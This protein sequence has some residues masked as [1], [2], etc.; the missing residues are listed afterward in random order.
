MLC[1][2]KTPRPDKL[3][4]NRLILLAYALIILT[5]SLVLFLAYPEYRLLLVF[6]FILTTVCCLSL[7]IKTIN[8]AEEAITY[9]GFANEIIKNKYE[10]IRIDNSNGEPVIQNDL[11]QEMFHNDNLLKFLENHL[12]GQSSNSAALYRLKTAY[13]DLVSEKVT[14]SLILQ[15]DDSKIF[16]PEEWYTIS[17]KPIYLKK[18]DIFEGKFSVKAIKKYTYIYWKL[19]NITASKNM[20]QVFQEERKS[21]HD[22]L[23][24]LPVGVYTCNEDYRIEYCNHALA[25]ALGYNRE[26]IIGENLWRFLSPHCELPEKHSLWKG[27][28]YLIGANDETKEYFVAQESFREDKE[29]KFRGVMISDLPNDTELQQ[30]LEHSLDEISWLFNDAPVGIA[31]INTEGQIQ[32][33]NSAVEKFLDREKGLIIGKRIFD[34]MR[35]EECDLLQKEMQSINGTSQ[36]SKAID[37]HITLD[38]SEKIASLYLSP[39]QK[40]HT[41]HPEQIDGLVV[42]VIDATQQKSLEMQFAQAQKMQA[43]GQMAGGVAHDFNNLLTAMIGF[44]DLLLQRHGVGDPS[45]TDLI[46][47][48]QNA[49]RAAGLVRQLLAFSRKQPLKPKLIDVTENF[50]EL[51]QMLKRILGEQIVLHFYH[52]NDLGFI[53]VDPVQFSQVIINLAVNAKDAMNGNGTL[54]ITTRVET[55]TTPYQFGADTIK[56]G[57]FVVIDVTDT[58]C[59]IPPENLNR[60]FEPFFSTKQNV[61]GS[62]TGLGLATVY[63]IVRQTEG[64]IKV[65]S[66]L[67]KGTTFSIHLPRF[68]KN[69]DEEEQNLIETKERIT[70][71]DGT[72]ILTVQEKRTSPIN[73][74]QKIIFGLNVSAIDRNTEPNH[75]AKDIKILFVEDEDSV[76]SFAVRALKKKGYEVIG[77]NSAENA[78]EQLEK[79]TDFDLLV[80]DMVMPGMSGAELA[81]I[82][83]TKIPNIK[84]IL[85]SGY[86]EEIARREL[87][88]SQDFEFMAKPFSLGDLTKKVFDVLNQK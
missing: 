24:Y 65:N 31:F 6:T 33:C 9:G 42:Y 52:G 77:C 63:G 54:S 85:A 32:D 49:N 5:I 19:E 26:E 1:S 30:H 81:G 39:M 4:Q 50:V 41:A 78:L 45:F 86:S 83:K 75:E 36:L 21:L 74:N 59:G 68:E 15:Q 27:N 46:Q 10:I 57:E 60:I 3:L 37:I 29:I 38:K 44:C 7:T 48:K 61:V 22:F 72:P 56:P 67:G 87:A 80:T 34:Y 8:A 79:E 12:S 84:I 35:P 82:I 70:A 64:F 2:L 20:E 28:L 40:L 69:T 23:D 25:N 13:N 14:L 71:K 58:G 51:S 53:R 55:L 88:G 47:I 76:R 66:T 17:L 18:T 62:G 11:A 73:I 43:M 16:T